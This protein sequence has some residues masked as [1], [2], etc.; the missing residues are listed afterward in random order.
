MFTGKELAT[1]AL[2]RSDSEEESGDEDLV[3]NPMKLAPTSN[4]QYLRGLSPVSVVSNGSTSTEISV[5]RLSPVPT[6]KHTVPTTEVLSL[7]LSL[8]PSLPFLLSTTTSHFAST[9]HHIIIYL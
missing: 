8:S 7:S 1:L 2:L 9:V 4:H 3:A 6:E 5:T